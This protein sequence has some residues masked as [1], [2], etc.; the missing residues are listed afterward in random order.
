MLRCRWLTGLTG[1]TDNSGIDGQ[2]RPSPDARPQAATHHGVG[3]GGD[4]E[5]VNSWDML[6]ALAQAPLPPVRVSARTMRTSVEEALMSYT[7]VDLE[8]VLADELGLDW[9]HADTTP[10]DADFTKRDLIRGY[11]TGW[12]LP[13]LVGLAR[14][15]V[16]EG[17]GPAA[18]LSNL[19]EVYDRDGGVGSPAKNLIFAANGPKPELVL[20]DAVNNDIE[21]VRNGEYCLVFD[22]PLPADGLRFSHLIKWWRTREQLDDSIGDR[23][24]GWALH[25]RLRASLGN[26]QAELAVFDAYAARYKGSLDTPVLIPQV[27]LHYDPQTQTARHRRGEVDAPLARQRMDFLLLFSDRHRVVLEVDGRQHYAKDDGYADPKLYAQMVA[28]DRRLRLTGYEI[29]RFGGAELLD[30]NALQML[31]TFFDD[32]AARMK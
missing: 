24:V 12:D 5:Q 7:R 9:L 3:T 19:L 16:S 31:T 2:Q 27:Y 10:D 25:A 8:V 30:T 11:T 6:A 21:I 32:L 22:Q 13:Q 1:G 18:E 15:L 28:E 17:H 29:Y 20:R 26:N 14:R 23:E 4:T